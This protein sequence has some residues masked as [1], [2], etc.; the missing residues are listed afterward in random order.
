[1]ITEISLSKVASYKNSTSLITDKRINLVYGLN[2]SGKS[3]LSNF[4]YDPSSAYYTNCKICGLSENDKIH[5]YNQQ[6]INDNF[7]AS[8]TLN[9]VFTLA[10]ENKEADIAIQSA[11]EAIVKLSDQK[12]GLDDRLIQT[13]ERERLNQANAENS[14]WKIKNDYHGGDRV[15]SYCF[16]QIIRSKDLL[17]NHICSIPKTEIG[18]ITIELLQKELMLVTSSTQ[19]SLQTLKKIEPAFSSIESNTL[20]ALVLVGNAN[21]SIAGALQKIGNSDWVKHGIEYIQKKDS[22]A[23]NCVCP[24]CLQ[25]TISPDFIH[26][27]ELYFNKE[28]EISLN[29]LRADYEN[30]KKAKDM[31]QSFDYYERNTFMQ[32]FMTEFRSMYS[33]LIQKI[34]ANIEII[35]EKVQNPSKIV[36]LYNTSEKVDELNCIIGKANEKILG[37]ITKLEK[38]KETESRI[39]DSFWK[40]LRVEYDDIIS[41]YLFEKEK[42]DK[43][44]NTLK[45]DI[46]HITNMIR[47]KENEKSQSQKKTQNIHGAI[48]NIK[49]GLQQLGIDS[50]TIVAFDDTHYR[51][52]RGEESANTFPSLS[53]GEK[54]IISFLYFL[55]I[56]KGKNSLQENTKKKILFID[57]PISSLSHIYVFNVGRII[58]EMFANQKQF[59]QIFV[60]TH[61]LY[62]FYELAKC[63]TDKSD[64]MNLYRLVKNEE[65]SRFLSMSYNEIQNDYQSYW[66]IVKDKNQP[67]AI[68][69]NC[70]RNILEYFFAFI[71]KQT[72][73]DAFD[74][75]EFRKENRFQAFYRY[76]N[77]E[78]HSDGV[79]IY[80]YSEFNYE[81]FKSAFCMVFTKAGYPEHYQKMMK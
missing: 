65:G 35:K 66:T 17:L 9:G 76:V 21:S 68:I 75:E 32:E 51:I 60:L 45:N 27:L 62:F 72:L 71:T 55:E 56:C 16:N 28:Y 50:F 70:M 57:D 47:E 40:V 8:Q 74:S 64:E 3:T 23:E 38:R 48:T 2:G 6:F 22:S 67:P 33:S 1:M 59:S 77:R 42:I 15:F 61:S 81:D 41:T 7:Y 10:K 69:A 5:V 30:Y 36:V 79:N 54:M 43:E 13:N 31:M 58:K 19:D 34:D 37:H 4:M 53:E 26:E 49:N 18:N 78:S 25:K 24:F 80:D 29:R 39:K 14:I 20:Y 44:K 11:N 63:K 52:C 12:K 46:E 73:R